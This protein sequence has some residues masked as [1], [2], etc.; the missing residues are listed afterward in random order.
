MTVSISVEH[1]SKQYRLGAIGN[2]TLYEDLNRWWARVRRRPDP[3]AKIGDVDHGNRT[4]GLIWALKDVSFAVDEG[5]ALGIIGRNGAGKSTL[6]KVLSKVTAPSGGRIKVRGRIASLLEVGTG[7]HPELTGRENIYLNGAI[8]GMT[9]R[10]IA[11]KF[12]E[13]VSFSEVEKFVDT[14]VKRYS[15]GMYVRLAFAVAAHL[16]PEIMVVDEVL[17]VGDAAFQRKCLG[18]MSETASQGRTVLFV[19]HNMA[20]INRL[21]SRA[22]LLDK[23]ELIADGAAPEITAKYLAGAA[24]ESGVRQWEAGNAP[25]TNE[26]RLLEVGIFDEQNKSKAV[27][28]VG[29]DIFIKLTYRVNE[30]N[31]RFRCALNFITQGVLA[32]SSVEPTEATRE[33]S[34]VYTSVLKV[35]AHLLTESEYALNVSIFSSAGAKKHY[36]NLRDGISFQ[37]YDSMMALSARGDYSQNLAGVVRPLLNW[38]IAQNPI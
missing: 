28:E 1:V 5:Q 10:E 13:I 11:K 35:P 16:D 2:R 34:G 19:S 17:A 38:T 23:G 37:V 20:A 6:L 4:D 33:K 12:D 9:R 3:L 22:V 29:E 30:S 25:G 24:E 31:L 32:F 26:L 14:P 21:C 8:L 18:K 36:V 27:F 7:F 15:S